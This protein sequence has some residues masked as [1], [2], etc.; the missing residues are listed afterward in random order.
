MGILWA[1]L[2]VFLVATGLAVFLLAVLWAF[3]NRSIAAAAIALLIW[4]IGAG[5]NRELNTRAL[6]H[7][8]KVIAGEFLGVPAGHS[9]G[10]R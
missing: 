8:P 2:F 1:V 5:V 10:R 7:G 9:R 6:G 3:I 4:G